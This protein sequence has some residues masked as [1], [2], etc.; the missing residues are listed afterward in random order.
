MLEDLAKPIHDLKGEVWKSG[1]VF[2]TPA[3]EEKIATRKR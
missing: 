3:I 2:D 1:G